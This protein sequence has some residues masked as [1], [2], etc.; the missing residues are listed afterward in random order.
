MAADFEN[1]SV[2]IERKH[3][4]ESN[5]LSHPTAVNLEKGDNNKN[6]PNE[7]KPSSSPRLMGK[8]G[9]SKVYVT[10]IYITMLS[11]TMGSLIYYFMIY[12]MVY[13]INFIHT[14][15]L[16]VFRTDV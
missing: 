7:R 4:P 10:T 14:L 15:H 9:K 3:S 6:C 5:K 2:S 11:Q 16:Y 1:R 12:V 8:D 13:K